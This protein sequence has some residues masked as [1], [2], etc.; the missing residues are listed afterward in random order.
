MNI[1]ISITCIALL[2][3]F[4]VFAQ[5]NTDQYNKMTNEILKLVN[6]HRLDMGLGVLS[7]NTPITAAAEKHS[8]NMATKKIPFGHDGFDQRMAGLRKQ[9]SNTSGWAENVALGAHTA[10]EAL[11]MWLKSPGH[12]K[13]IEGDYNL[14]GIGIAKSKDGDLYLTQIFFKK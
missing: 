5:H 12:K 2:L 9:I 11:D 10:E 4:H 8:K 14:T 13:N 7:T 3:S 6:K 1:R